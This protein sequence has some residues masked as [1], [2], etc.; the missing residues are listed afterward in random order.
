MSNLH[1]VTGF[2]GE[3]HITSAD[4]GSFNAAILGTG[5]YVLARGKM[6]EAQIISNNVVRVLDGDICMHGRHI[7]LETGS[8]VDLNFENGAQDM[9]R[10]DLIVVRYTRDPSSGIESAELAVLK[11]EECED[12]DET[13]DYEAIPTTGDI[14]DGSATIHEMALY[15]ILFDG[16]TIQEPEQYFTLMPVQKARLDSAYTQANSAYTKANGAYNRANAAYNQAN[17]A[18]SRINSTTPYIGYNTVSGNNSVSLGGSAR[19][20]QVA[21]VAV[22]FEANARGNCA[23]AIGAWAEALFTGYPASDYGIA[24]GCG[25]KARGQASIAIGETTQASYHAVA[26]GPGA[27]ANGANATALGWGANASGSNSTALGW[28]AATAN[29][30]SIQLGSSTLSSITAKVSITTTSD[31]RDKADITELDDGALDFLR[32]IRA[33]R[34]VWNGRELYIDEDSLTDEDKKIRAKYGLCRYD[35]AAHAAGTKKGDRI[36]VGVLAQETQAALKEVFGDSGYANLVNDNLFDFENVPDDVEN[37]LGVSYE[38]FIPFLI[39]AVQ[40]IADRLDALEA[41]E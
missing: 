8:Y 30:N 10:R 38:N 3:E 15:S 41:K 22:G 25:A 18:Y 9:Y 27:I 16:L 20:N 1:L 19:A 34:Y 12:I 4:Q 13:Y 14:I 5:D 11:G 36:R 39:K 7:R 24:V 37:Q 26:I 31:E 17:N 21:A 32:K 29:A 6:F 23:I 40:E 2:A 35:K 28:N 33:I